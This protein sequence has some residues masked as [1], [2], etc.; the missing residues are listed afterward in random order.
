MKVV[1]KGLYCTRIDKDDDPVLTVTYGM[2]VGPRDGP[3]IGT[4]CGIEMD[5][6]HSPMLG[7]GSTSLK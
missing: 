4:A 2:D 5:L 6:G 1:V 3:V 7:I